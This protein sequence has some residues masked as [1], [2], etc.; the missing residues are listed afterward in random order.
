MNEVGTLVGKIISTNGS[1][2]KGAASNVSDIQMIIEVILG[3]PLPSF[4]NQ[5]QSSGIFS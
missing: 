5:G 4:G 2:T 3:A 1:N